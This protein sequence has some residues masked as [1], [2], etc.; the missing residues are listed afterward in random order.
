MKIEDLLIKLPNLRI[1]YALSS[2]TFY[3]L[4]P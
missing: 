1:F 4:K 2:S 3:A